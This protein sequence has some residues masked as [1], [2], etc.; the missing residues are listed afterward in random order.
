MKTLEIKFEGFDDWDRAT[1]K[2]KDKNVRFA[3]LDRLFDNKEEALKYAK[4]NTESIELKGSNFN[5]E[6]EGGNS[7]K[8]SFKFLDDE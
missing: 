8:W 4:E 1:F 3:I 7:P 2:L 5:S 6:P